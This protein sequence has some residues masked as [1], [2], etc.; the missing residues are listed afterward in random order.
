MV[1]VA[2]P[3]DNF[4]FISRVL[5][6]VLNSITLRTYIYSAGLHMETLFY[7]LIVSEAKK[8]EDYSNMTAERLMSA[9]GRIKYI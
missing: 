9:D 6:T 1:I 3:S 5:L 7:F 8:N 4:F 2:I